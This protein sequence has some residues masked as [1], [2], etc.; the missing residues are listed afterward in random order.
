MNDDKQHASDYST[1]EVEAA[2]RVLIEVAQNLGD[3]ADACVLIGGWVPELLILSPETEHTG[4]IDVDLALNPELLTESNYASL[5]DTLKQKGYEAGDKPFQLRKEVEVEGRKIPV[6]VEFLA[7]KGAKMKK[8][9]P[10]LVPGFRVLQ[11]A[12][13]SLAF[14][15]PEIVSLEG[16]MP[17]GRKNRVTIRVAAIEDEV[18]MKGYAL[19]GRDKPKD[20]YDVY[21]CV[22]NYPG[23]PIKLAAALRPRLR[24]KEVRTGLEHIAGKFRHEGDFGPDTVARFLDKSDEADRAFD[25]RDA[26]EQVSR[27][28]SELKL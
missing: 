17:D 28:I 2:H 1:A 4:S 24:D 16:K 7:P 11:A 23:G 13:C 26:F 3:Y 10:K 6:D 5:L 12:G 27:F 8:H 21:F 25:R 20:A 15:K 9:K 22:K 14:H 18:V 19:A